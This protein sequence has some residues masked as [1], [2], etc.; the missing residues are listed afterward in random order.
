MHPDTFLCYFSRVFGL[1]F[2]GLA[3]KGLR[4]GFM[5]L[6]PKLNPKPY[7]SRVYTH[8]LQSLPWPLGVTDFFC[9][10]VGEIFLRLGSRPFGFDKGF[11]WRI[12]VVY[13]V[14]NHEI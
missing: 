10:N 8:E 3:F 1:G 6:N 7:S 9:N 4:L 13:R 11:I 12:I 14:V 2:R 5:T